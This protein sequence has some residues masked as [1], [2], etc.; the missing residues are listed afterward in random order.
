MVRNG[1]K[2]RQPS[3]INIVSLLPYHCQGADVLCHNTLRSSTSAENCLHITY[4]FHE[5]FAPFLRNQNFQIHHIHHIHQFSYQERNILT[6]MLPIFGFLLYV[7]AMLIATKVYELRKSGYHEVPLAIIGPSYPLLDSSPRPSPGSE[8]ANYTAR[9]WLCLIGSVACL[10]TYISVFIWVSVAHPSFLEEVHDK[11]FISTIDTDGK[12]LQ[13]L[14]R[15]I[16][17]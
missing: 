2:S 13:G 5:K 11:C 17:G 10:V 4:V 7:V 14:G 16:N 12:K 6:K 1:P 15:A 3:L 8:S 9:E